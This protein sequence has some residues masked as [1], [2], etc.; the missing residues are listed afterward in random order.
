MDIGRSIIAVGQ[1]KRPLPSTPHKRCWPRSQWILKDCSTDRFVGDQIVPDEMQILREGRHDATG[2][3][4]FSIRRTFA[5]TSYYEGVQSLVSR[6]PCT[7]IIRWKHQGQHCSQTVSVARRDRLRM[8]ER[9]Y[10]PGVTF[11]SNDPRTTGLSTLLLFPVDS[12]E[13]AFQDAHPYC[14]ITRRSTGLII[15]LCSAA[16]MADAFVRTVRPVFIPHG[17][18]LGR[19]S[20][21]MQHTMN[22]R[23]HLESWD[24]YSND[25]I[26]WLH[27]RDEPSSTA[28]SSM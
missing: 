20:Q 6:S 16:S 21:A 18:N 17:G 15:V 22:Y 12:R 8:V 3:S 19:D 25:V 9:A 7:P 28:K 4:P 24:S 13:D 23:T 10:E 26:P 5:G 1:Q 11:A 14:T 27:Q 2:L